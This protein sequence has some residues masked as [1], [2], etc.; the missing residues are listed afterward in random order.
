LGD[1]PKFSPDI[2]GIYLVVFTRLCLRDGRLR[3]P[4]DTSLVGLAGLEFPKQYCRPAG[5]IPTLVPTA[6]ARIVLPIAVNRI[7]V[8]CAPGAEVVGGSGVDFQ[9]PGQR[10]SREATTRSP[11][12][13]RL[14]W[15]RRQT[16]D[17]R[18]LSSNS[19]PIGRSRAGI[20]RALRG[21]SSQVSIANRYLQIGHNLDKPKTNNRIKMTPRQQVRPGAQSSPRGARREPGAS[22]QPPAPP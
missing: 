16:S 13:T 1:R 19:R 2:P 12:S 4:L 6:S 20:I 5:Q 10:L 21:G 18:P 7:E 11:P 22:F 15:P 14:W 3:T 17:Q 9:F 8:C